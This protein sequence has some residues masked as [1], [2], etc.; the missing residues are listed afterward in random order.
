[1]A[2]GT[3]GDRFVERMGVDLILS[4]GAYTGIL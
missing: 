1:M 4:T 3:G 2:L